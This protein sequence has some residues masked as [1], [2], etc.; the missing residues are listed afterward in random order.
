MS[1]KLTEIQAIKFW[2]RFID[3]VIGIWRGSRRSFDNFVKTLNQETMKYGIKFPMKEIQFGKSVN[4]LDLTVYLD[5]NNQLHHRSYTKPTDSKRFLNPKSFHPQFVFDSVPFSQLLRTM[6]NNSNPETMVVE[7]KKCVSDFLNS[8]YKVEKLQK[9]KEKAIERS[10]NPREETVE[11]ETLVFPVHFFEKLEE[12]KSVVYNL[13]DEIGELIGDTRVMFAVKKHSSIGNM[14]V[15]NKELSVKEKD[16][17]GQKCNAPGCQQCPL[18]H[19]ENRFIVNGKS[20]L[21]PKYLNCKSKNI[22]Y[23]WTCKL[24]WEAY[25]GRT[26]QPCHN[27]T[28]GHRSCFNV[29]DK[30][31]KSALSMHARD[32]HQMN[33][34][35]DIFNIAVIKKVSP[36]RI[37]REEFKFIDKYRTASLGLNRY[38]S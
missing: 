29:E 18:V 12:F 16:I 8:G 1:P 17:N 25:F 10:Q 20:V 34:S 33:F 7:S 21:A 9:L 6:R 3:D 36:Q 28:S 14:M 11:T 22:I 24:C 37:R 2:N 30:W 35:L 31:D 5:E 15:K 19:Q 4:S 27:R 32:V 23:M 26:V 38:K 13:K